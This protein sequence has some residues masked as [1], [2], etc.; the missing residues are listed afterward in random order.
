MEA[1]RFLTP[2]RG[3]TRWR[4][5]SGKGATERRESVATMRTFRPAFTGF[6]SENGATNW[7]GNGFSG[8]MSSKMEALVLERLKWEDWN[9]L[10][11]ELVIYAQ[12]QIPRRWWRGSHDG[13]L[14]EGLDAEGVAQNI[15]L[16]AFTGM[17]QL[18][19]G[20]TRQRLLDELK[21]LVDNEL[22]RLNSRME[23]TLMLNEWDVLPR[24]AEGELRSIFERRQAPCGGGELFNKELKAAD[25]QDR[26]E[27]EGKL[28]GD[29]RAKGVLNC[30]YSGVRKRRDIAAK[31][32]IDVKVVTA[33][34]KRLERKAKEEEIVLKE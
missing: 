10:R 18:V 22:R 28:G 1:K 11:K 5:S 8:G 4:Q 6:S 25:E 7:H 2:G 27:L 9:T 24:D 26:Q 19:I 15:V 23:A 16:K 21:R 31:L 13:V 34:R 3:E 17:S 20:W 32:G 33:A 30:L 29:E 14:P 12:E